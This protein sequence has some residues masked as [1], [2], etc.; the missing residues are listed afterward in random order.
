VCLIQL[1]TTKEISDVYLK[2]WWN[3][4]DKGS[5]K[6]WR[7]TCPIVTKSTISPTQT[8]LGLNPFLHRK[9]QTTNKSH[10]TAS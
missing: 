4:A 1:V 8:E 10:G 5:Q 6:N 7:E 9:R 3:G 2:H